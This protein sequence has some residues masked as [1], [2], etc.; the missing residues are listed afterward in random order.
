[1]RTRSTLALL[2]ANLL[3]FGL[4]FYLH[5]QDGRNLGG[6]DTA[7]RVFGA[8]ASNLDYLEIRLPDEE[9]PRVLRREAEKWNIKSPIQWPA[10]FFAI[11]RIL[12]QIEF[13]EK[14]ASFRASDLK[15]TGQ[16]L[17]NY[18]LETP[19]AELVFGRGS[20]RHTV[21]V[22]ASTDIGNRL[23]ILDPTGEW[24]H[25]VHRDFGESL[26]LQL[27]DLRS[28]TIFHIPLFEVRSLNVQLESHSKIRLARS[29]G[30][31]LFETPFQT[32]ADKRSVEAVINRLNSLQIRSFE[33]PASENGQYGL[34][35]PAL[36]VTLEG[37]SRRETLLVGN[38]APGRGDG[39]LYAK[40]VDNPTIFAVPA[41][42]L[43]AVERAQDLLRDR[44][45]LDVDRGAIS[46]VS[47][48]LPGAAEVLLQKLENEQWQT[49][50]RHPDQSVR[51][52]PADTAL[53]E[54]LLA[55]L[56]D[57]HVLKFEN[58]APSDADLVRYG[59]D[60]PQ[61]IITMGSDGGSQLVIGSHVPDAGGGEVY[62]KLNSNR[63]VY[64]VDAS[65]L[66]EIPISTQY[67]R[68]RLLQRQPDG[69]I[70]SS[71]RIR[72]LK[73]DEVM[74][75]AALDSP[76]A[77]WQQT[78]AELPEKERTAI[79]SLLPEL[80][81]LRV[82]RY[83]LDEF[84]PTIAL[85]G[86]DVSFTYA[87][88]AD[89]LLVGGDSPRESHFR[90]FLTDRLGGQTLIAGSEELNVVF[91]ARQSLIDA[92]APLLFDRP[93]PSAEEEVTLSANG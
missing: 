9:E 49:V 88:E 71:L 42:P 30:E 85:D 11:N 4:I 22:G 48:S 75:E 44:K 27:S 38:A 1:M 40:L 62:A 66:R 28:D 90:I 68:D 56:E 25:V 74:F 65:L 92:L 67:F 12:Q 86:K 17:A 78:V 80:R 39:L 63:F 87:L 37:N 83:V 69:A 91:A 32:R 45:L 76:E 31:W 52:L 72:R 6:V 20:Q 8:E 36:R 10:N 60:S 35:N 59:F 29:D 15:R 50:S 84:S 46:S 21:Q 26:S 23:Y 13:L 61:R 77:S 64:T 33:N 93:S 89:L 3:L 57:A 18:G 2:A 14:E 53:V 81:N 5:H 54:R 19:R 58:D 82:Q 24:I 79:L 43:R 34:S 73:D 70:I 51:I 7:R 55:S 16:T 41:E 47:L